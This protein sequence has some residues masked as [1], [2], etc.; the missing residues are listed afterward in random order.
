EAVVDVAAAAVG[1]PLR[2]LATQ[3]LD[4]AGLGPARHAQLLGPVQR[5]HLDVRAAD[6]LGDRDRHF[7]LEVVALA[8]EHRRLLD[9]RD[10]VEIAGGAA[11]QAGLALAGQPDPRA[12]LDAGGDVDLVLLEVAH[13]ALAVAGVAGMLD[14]RPR[15][16][17][18]VARAG[19]REQALALGLDAAAVADRADDRRRAR[20]GAGAAAGRAG[21]VRGDGDRDLRALDRLVEGERHRRLQVAPALGRRLRPRP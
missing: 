5:R 21:R 20:L 8:P 16:A 15:A 13:P 7:D 3:A 12:L 10:H 17:A 1:Q 6:R 18:L 9:A 11:A 19:D 4:R 2:A 14:D